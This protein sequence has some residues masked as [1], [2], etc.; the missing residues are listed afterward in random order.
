M[1]RRDPERLR[2]LRVAVRY[3]LREEVLQR[4]HQTRLAEHFNVS[5]QRVHQVVNEEQVRREAAIAA[6]ASFAV[7][8]PQPE[9]ESERLTL[10]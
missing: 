8:R 10:P 3:L 9:P 5:R 1:L 7:A 6:R 4:G 2:K